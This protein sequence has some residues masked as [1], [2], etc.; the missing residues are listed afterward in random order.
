MFRWRAFK[1]DKRVRNSKGFID[2]DLVESFLDL[3]PHKMR[4]V[5]D[6]LGIS[7]DELIKRIE[8]LSQA[9]H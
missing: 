7:V 1:N 8:D 9:L 4:E 2:G 6:G 5:V 3:S